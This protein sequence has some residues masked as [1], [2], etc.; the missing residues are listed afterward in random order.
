MTLDS[1][2]TFLRVRL[3]TAI[4][5]T[6]DIVDTTET[7]ALPDHSVI[8]S[9]SPRARWIS[10]S[11][12][13]L[14]R[15][16]GIAPVRY[17]SAISLKLASELHQSPLAIAQQIGRAYDT[18]PTSPWKISIDI[19]ATGWLTLSLPYTDVID[20]L[21]QSLTPTS[22]LHVLD[23]THLP[24]KIWHTYERCRSLRSHL[25]FHFATHPIPSTRDTSG[26]LGFQDTQ[27]IAA[28]RDL[29]ETLLDWMDELDSPRSRSTLS[30]SPSTPHS[31]LAD[32]FLLDLCQSF[33]QLHRQV[34]LFHPAITRDQ[35]LQFLQCLAWVQ[36]AIERAFLSPSRH[37]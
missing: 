15:L 17:Q 31:S 26:L 6:V 29:I 34:P 30:R 28:H 23:E 33:H 22:S 14:H 7:I 25:D 11:Q 16:P 4:S 10:G 13:P 24:F 2:R 20:V 37:P 21:N 27:T 8:R 12:I 32:Q 35:Q 1:L 36:G 3:Y 18:D 5:L 19:N 9:I